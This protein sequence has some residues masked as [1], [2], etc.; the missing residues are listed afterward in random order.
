MSDERKFNKRIN[1]S[2][3]HKVRK[4]VS[5]NESGDVYG[6]TIPREMALKFVDCRIHLF[7]SG[8]AII[9]EKDNQSLNISPQQFEDITKKAKRGN[10]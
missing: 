2:K 10:I 6:I 9:M 7:T 5:G 4:I 1:P 8:N 3:Y